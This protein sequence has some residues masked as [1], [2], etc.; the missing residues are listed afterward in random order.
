MSW[1]KSKNKEARTMAL[2]GELGEII[3]RRWAARTVTTTP[4]TTLLSQLV[5]HR[6]EGHGKYAG[7]VAP[8]GDFDKVWATA[9]AASGLPAGAKIP[10]GRIFHDFRR[11][12]AR[13]LRRAGNAENVC[14]KITGHRTPSIFHRY[15]IVDEQDIA[16]ALTKMQAHLLSQPVERLV[17]PIVRAAENRR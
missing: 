5:F 11:S 4:G 17:A 7:D 9:C 8:V 6:G 16:E 2:V 15:S 3:D 14:M 10:G 13:N 1:R 12:C